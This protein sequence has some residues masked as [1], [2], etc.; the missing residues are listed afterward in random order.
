MSKFLVVSYYCGHPIYKESSVRLFESAKH[1]GFQCII[2]EVPSLGDWWAN[3]QYKPKFILEQMVKHHPMPIVWVDVDAEFMLYPHMFDEYYDRND[4]DVAVHVLDHS[5]Y[6]RKNHPPEMLSG[7]V[8]LKNNHRTLMLVG[9]WVNECK[10][11]PKLWDQ[12]ALQT[13]LNRYKFTNLPEEYCTIF[14]Y[15]KSVQN[16]VIVHHQASRVAKRAGKCN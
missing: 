7:T 9:E 4:V 6:R 15:M 8:Y 2:S 10:K 12:H 16:P 14:D 1:L 13:V 11:D 3:M 5:K